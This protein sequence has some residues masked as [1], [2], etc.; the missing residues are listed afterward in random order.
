MGIQCQRFNMSPAA[1][2]LEQI[3]NEDTQI[4]LL[5]RYITANAALRQALQQHDWAEVAR[6]YNGAD[7]AEN[8]YDTKL[9]AAYA[10]F[11]G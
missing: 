11:Q 3:T 8:H 1:F 9:A 6:L 2:L 4:A 5:G 10:S 7:Y